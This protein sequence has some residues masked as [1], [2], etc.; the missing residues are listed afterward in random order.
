[1]NR[2]ES[3]KNILIGAVAGAAI[4]TAP[5]CKTE[6]TAQK[7]VELPN[8][9]RTPAEKAHDVKVLGETF[10]DD[11][12]MT[13]IHTL[14]E[15]ILPATTTAASAVQAGVPDF[16]EFIVKDLPYHQIP[17]RGGL[18]WLDIESNSRFDKVFADCSKEEQ[19]QIVDDI[20]YPD[21]NNE[22]PVFAQGI[23]FFDKIRGL[24]LTGYYTS[25]EGIADLGYKGN[26][27]NVWDGVPE[28]VL[29]KHNLAY[30]QDWLAKCVDQS[31]RDIIAEWDDNMNLI[32]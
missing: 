7:I 21:P 29:K 12:E 9:G 20:A 4:T 19:I 2:R 5:S 22:K 11:H 13:T 27:P 25:K 32:T 24:I 18:M 8:Y 30:E 17:L 1:M 14:C 3:F 26:Q 28:D 16:L 10:F 15:I 23:Q 6:E 31:K